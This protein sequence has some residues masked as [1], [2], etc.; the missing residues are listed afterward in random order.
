MSKA[1]VIVIGSNSTRCVAADLSNI[2]AQPIRSRVE[3][4]LFLGMEKNSPAP[5]WRIRWRASRP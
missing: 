3:T 4:R 1:A 5:P 2:Q